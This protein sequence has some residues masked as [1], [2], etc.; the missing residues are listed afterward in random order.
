MNVGAWEMGLAVA[1]Y[2]AVVVVL[3][4][5]SRRGASSSPDEYFLAGRGLGPLVLFM[6]LFGTNATSFVLVGIPAAAYE[7]GIG[8]FGLNAPIVALGIPLTFWAVGSPARRM[9]KRLGA[10]TPAELYAARFGSRACGFVLFAVFTAYTVPYMVQ[11]VKSAALILHGVSGGV[12]STS[13]VG[14][15]V[16][17]VA[18]LYTSLGGMR[19][20]AWTNVFQG[21]LFLVFMVAAFFLVADSLGGLRAATSAVMEVEPER[22]QLGTDWLFEPRAWTSWGLVI[23]LTVIGFPHMF[24]RLLAA[25]DERAIRTVSRAY[26]IALVFLWTPAVFL[27]V[28]GVAA[29]EGLDEPDRI[30]QLMTGTHL[31]AALGTL[32]FLAV[33]AAVMSTLDAQILTLSSMVVRDVAAPLGWSAERAQVLLGRLFAAAIGAVIW[34]LSEVWDDSIFGISRKAFEGYTTLF[35]ALLLGVR[36][37][38]LTAGGLVSSVV[39]GNAVL[40]LGWIGWLPT[41]GFLPV[42]WALLAGFA[43]AFAVSLLGPPPA[44]ERTARAFG[45]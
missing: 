17:A 42:F 11:A 5:R 7:H 10:L 12:L 26:P 22:L 23:S 3:G 9:A 25:S 35:P 30:F 21:S 13:V 40:V 41:A 39:V 43:A 19:A 33:L 4:L 31:P 32:G 20:T 27:G 34:I 45:G 37:R 29:F 16:V 44:A 1:V 36:W 18:L 38:R 8:V 15:G 24:V 6:A 14:L 2:V 28:W